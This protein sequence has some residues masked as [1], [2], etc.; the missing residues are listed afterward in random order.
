MLSMLFAVDVK[1]W[2]KWATDVTNEVWAKWI[3]SQ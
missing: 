3:I 2:W 1:V